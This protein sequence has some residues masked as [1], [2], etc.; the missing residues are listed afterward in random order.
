M[1][2]KYSLRLKSLPDFKAVTKSTMLSGSEQNGFLNLLFIL[3][4]M[5]SV[6]GAFV[7]NLSSGEYALGLVSASMEPGAAGL[8]SALWSCGKFHLLVLAAAS[9]LL[10]VAAVPVLAVMRGY[11][12]SCGA[13]ALIAGYP[14][15]GFLIVLAII[16]LP[17]MF[18]V[19]S[20]F[21]LSSWAMQ[22]SARL[23]SAAAGRAK[24][25]SCGSIMIPLLTCICSVSIAAALEC[26]AVPILL[27]SLAPDL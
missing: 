3:F 14:D 23:I 20:F 1:F 19:P 24:V 17:G 18:S 10:G 4:I 27:K 11:L 9:S 25:K 21:M 12:I 5:G 7:G 13:A 16:G 6:V 8:L 26:F 15:K 2:K 22:S